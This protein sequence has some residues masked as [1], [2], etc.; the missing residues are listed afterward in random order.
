MIDHIGLIQ[1]FTLVALVV[2]LY[3]T[4][5][6]LGHSHR[7]VLVELTELCLAAV[8]FMVGGA[9]LVGRHDMILLFQEIGLGQWL[10][11]L[12]GALEVSGAA[13][14]IVPL[15]SVGSAFLL[16]AI[17]VVATLI[18]L[19]VLHRPP[20]A[21]LACLSGHTFVVWARMSR[22]R[23]QWLRLSRPRRAFRGNKVRRA[24]VLGGEP[25][26][27]TNLRGE[28]THDQARGPGRRPV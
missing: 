20:V 13:L 1:V 5:R 26:A 28:S 9:K 11:Y 24:L 16:G 23:Q 2:A 12:T 8:F 19:F 25:L 22:P 27:L 18:E 4:R 10:R 7:L 15:F 14:L 6:T 17:M 3:I 21:A